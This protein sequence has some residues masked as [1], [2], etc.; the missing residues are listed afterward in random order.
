MRR[1]SR[2][3]TLPAHL[4]QY[5]PA[6]WLTPGYDDPTDPLTAHYGALTEYRWARAQVLGISM[7]EEGNMPVEWRKPCACGMCRHQRGEIERPSWLIPSHERHT[8]PPT[9]YRQT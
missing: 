8:W 5:D 1:R 6:E 7:P 4:E 3:R 2:E 9:Q